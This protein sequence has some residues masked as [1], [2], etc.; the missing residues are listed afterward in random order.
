MARYGQLTAQIL[1][2]SEHKFWKSVVRTPG[3]CWKWPRWLDKNGYGRF[4]FCPGD[5]LTYRLRSHR[6]SYFFSTGILL[7]SDVL[8]CHH[9]DNPSCVNPEHLF[10]G[11]GQD[12]MDDMNNKS[13]GRSKLTNDQIV[14]IRQLLQEDIKLTYT[15]LAKQFHVNRPTINAIANYVSWPSL[16]VGP[17]PKR[18][19]VND[20]DRKHIKELFASGVSARKI[21][22]TFGICHHTVL[23]VIRNQKRRKS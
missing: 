15:H 18:S 14:Q 3:K 8:V 17:I 4:E 10:R 23:L 22:L 5:G 13:R 16:D 1:R 21:G 11:T 20:Q 7:P 12:N 9:C 2:G 6:A 19:K